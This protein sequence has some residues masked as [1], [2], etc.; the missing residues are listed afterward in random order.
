MKNTFNLKQYR[1]KAYYDDGKG[2]ILPQSRAMMNCYKTKMEKG[3]SAHEASESC[4]K[5][6]QTMKDWVGNYSAHGE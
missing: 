4:I 6:F 2:L 3:N 5:E 1:K